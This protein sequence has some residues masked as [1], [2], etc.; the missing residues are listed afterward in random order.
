[1]REAGVLTDW[2]L[3]LGRD[4]YIRYINFVIFDVYLVIRGSFHK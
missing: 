2:L 1:M 4:S 3:L